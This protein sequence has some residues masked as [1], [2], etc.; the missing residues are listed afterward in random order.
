VAALIALAAA[1][2]RAA[3][4][5]PYVTD[6]PVP[7]ERGHWEVYQFATATR[8]AGTTS[9]EAGLD[10]NYGAADNLHLTLVL[11]AQFEQAGD[12]RWSGGTIELAAKYRIMAAKSPGGGLEVAV[13]P[14][15]F[16]PTD[17]GAG[18]RHPSLL[19]PVWIGT[20]QGSWGWFG[21]GGYLINPGEGN[22]DAWLGGLVATRALGERLHVG[23]ELYHRSAVA[24]DGG[25]FTG[26]NLGFEFQFSRYW[27]LLGSLG[28]GVQNA[29][30]EGQ[31]VAYIAL[32][33]AY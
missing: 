15:L 27:S 11:P 21:G 19:L 24:D 26:V 8:A 7:V 33:A 3:A 18:A 16:V 32:R 25:A 1:A 12:T 23:V 29:R 17:A 22:R 5:P 10:I 4:G 13:F 20:D 31:A 28:P 2:P 14:R 9:G 6:D 30:Q